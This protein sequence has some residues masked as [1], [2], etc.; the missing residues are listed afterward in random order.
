MAKRKKDKQ[1]ST[2]HYSTQKTK[3]RTTWTPLKTKGELRCFG[4]V[5]SSCSTS[6][7]RQ[8]ENQGLWGEGCRLI[9]A[10]G[11]VILPLQYIDCAYYP[12][13]NEVAKGYSNAVL[14]SV[15]P[16]FCN[17]LVNTL[18]STSFNGFWPNFSLYLV[19]KRIWNPIDFQGQRSRSPSQIFTA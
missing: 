8:I 5:S 2:K 13:T 19:L 14:P 17:I 10:S 7:T 4:R 1:R 9:W 3:D 16:S 18:G 15:R 12:L 11:C 6:D